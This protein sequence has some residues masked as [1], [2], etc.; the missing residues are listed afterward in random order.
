MT[1]AAIAGKCTFR[2]APTPTLSDQ[3]HQNDVVVL[4]K[5]H[6]AI[7]G[8]EAE[9]GTTTYEVLDVLRALQPG[10][11]RKG[12]RL[13]LAG[14]REGSNS[15]LFLLFGTKD[16]KL[17]WGKPVNI[18]ETAYE[19]I[20]QAPSPKLPIQ[21]R[22]AYFVNYLEH[23][24]LI[25]AT[26][27]HAEFE[28]APNDEMKVSAKSLSRDKFHSYLSDPN[29]NSSRMRIYGLILGLRGNDEDAEMMGK[30]IA[31]PSEN[32]RLGIDGV[33]A[34][35][36]LLTGEAGLERIENSKLR[37]KSIVFS[38]TYATMQALRFMWQHGEGHI[39]QERLRE[40]MR[41][42]L[43]RPELAD[44]VIN[45]LARM[46][47]WESQERL[48]ALYGEGEYNIPSIKRAIVRFLISS[49]KDIPDQANE[50][51][52]NGNDADRPEHVIRGEK[53]LEEIR[54]KDP[55]TVAEVKRFF[56]VK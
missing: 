32:F 24:D 39:S 22:L 48:A 56:N 20:E 11:P 27:A 41:I 51:D 55:K 52:I 26:D 47:D 1:H 21:K 23:A 36:L 12:E 14:H 13:E 19:Y 42:L 49:T 40:S 43:D 50:D 3:V 44:L 10:A 8:I 31:Q 17:E 46:K 28:N 38:E 2:A 9:S 54:Q 15:D 25:V 37:D 35:Y 4:V 53:L 30:L 6:T 45:D 5:W 16:R 29:V 33:M 18:S 34:G 7:K